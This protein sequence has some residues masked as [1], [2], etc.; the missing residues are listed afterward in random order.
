MLR[1]CGAD[2]ENRIAVVIID[3]LS[4]DVPVRRENASL[5]GSWPQVIFDKHVGSTRLFAF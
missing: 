3:Q 4:S 2:Y 5:H 1:D